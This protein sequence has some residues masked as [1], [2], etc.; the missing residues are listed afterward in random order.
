MRKTGK[1]IS[2]TANQFERQEWLLSATSR[3]ICDF[4]TYCPH[5]SH[6]FQFARAA[7]DIRISKDA[8]ILN[9]RIYWL[10]LLV[11]I[12]TAA[13]VALTVVLVV[14]TVKLTEHP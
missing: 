1:E 8:E 7:L 13:L 5:D 14:L 11:A 12:L 2:Q 3:E 4:F 6:A 10:T 9:R